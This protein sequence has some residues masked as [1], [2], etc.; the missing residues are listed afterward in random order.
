MYQRHINSPFSRG[1]VYNKENVPKIYGRAHF[2]NCIY[3][4]N[5][6]FM[7]KPRVQSLTEGN[8]LI[9]FIST[10]DTDSLE[11]DFFFLTE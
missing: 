3:T 2:F 7:N 10:A 9:V 1:T 4:T 5:K 11:V 6:E 8:N